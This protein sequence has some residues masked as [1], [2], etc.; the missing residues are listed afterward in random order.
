MG[1][2]PFLEQKSPDRVWLQIYVQP[3]GSRTQIVGVHQS[4]LKVKVTAP[5]EGGKANEELLR[6]LKKRM[7]S[8]RA[9]LTLIRGATSRQKTIEVAPA[10][11]DEMLEL[12]APD[13][14]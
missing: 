9:E 2:P 3:G 10:R 11:V 5:P 6:F 8:L 1:A 13:E 7:R 12:F 4:R 14:K